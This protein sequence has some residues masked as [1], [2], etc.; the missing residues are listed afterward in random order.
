MNYFTMPVER[1]RQLGVVDVVLGMNLNALRTK[2]PL[3]QAVADVS[4]RTFGKQYRTTF[5]DTQIELAERAIRGADHIITISRTS[6]EA[7]HHGGLAPSKVTVAPLGVGDEFWNVSAVNVAR[8]RSTYRLPDAFVL[9]VGGINERKNIPVL[10]AALEKLG[11][12][13]PL[14][15]AGPTPAEPLAFWG[16]DRPWVRH[17]GYIPEGDVPPL[18]AAA[19]IKVFPSKLEGY[20]LPLVEAMAVGTP[21]LAADI[22]VFREIG[23]DGAC[24]FPPDDPLTLAHLIQMAI[25]SRGFRDEYRGRGREVAALQTWAEYGRCLLTALRAAGHQ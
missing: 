18:Y 19:T 6:A 24:F 17:I 11:G 3:L 13:V 5:N 1:I 10:I 9:Y 21:V 2:A 8:I 20:G 15:L 25:G 23:G 16:L 22:P 4:W 7:L 14:V 12:V